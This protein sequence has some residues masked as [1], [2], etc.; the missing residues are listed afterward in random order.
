[1]SRRKKITLATL[2]PCQRLHVTSF[3][4]YRK[5]ESKPRE[6][7]RFRVAHAPESVCKGKTTMTI[8]RNKAYETAHSS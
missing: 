2:V 6:K 8:N 1:L 7:F 3:Y 5:K 4:Q